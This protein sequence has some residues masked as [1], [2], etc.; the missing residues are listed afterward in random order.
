MASLKSSGTEASEKLYVKIIFTLKKRFT[1][2]FLKYRESY[3]LLFVFYEE[4]LQWMEYMEQ[5]VHI[6]FYAVF[7]CT[8]YKIL[9]NTYILEAILQHFIDL[10]IRC[11]LF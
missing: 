4:L 5:M 6:D 7:L 8:I 9:F 10:R 3:K 1:S 11:F 2:S